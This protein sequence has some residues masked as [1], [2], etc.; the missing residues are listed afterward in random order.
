MIG[1][2][3]LFVALCIFLY[4]GNGLSKLSFILPPGALSFFE[5]MVLGITYVCSAIALIAMVVE[6]CLFAAG[7]LK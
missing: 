3:I 1:V 7:A 2:L 4:I 6:I 5:D